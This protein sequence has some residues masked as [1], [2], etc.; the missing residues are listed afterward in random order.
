MRNYTMENGKLYGVDQHHWKSGSQLICIKN[1]HCPT[2]VR[3]YMSKKYIKTRTCIRVGSQKLINNHKNIH[4]FLANKF[5]TFLI[6][7]SKKVTD[8]AL[9]NGISH[10]KICLFFRISSH[11]K[12]CG[13]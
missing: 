10:R 12:I 7:T 6:G 8:I 5:R 3:V 2:L 13:L 11:I 9:T 4:V 1:A